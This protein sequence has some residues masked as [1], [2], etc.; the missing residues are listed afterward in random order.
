MHENTKEQKLLDFKKERRSNLLF[1]SMENQ[2]IAFFFR[3]SSLI[4][5]NPSIALHRPVANSEVEKLLRKKPFPNFIEGD[6]N[7]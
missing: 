5:P 6:L 3:T 1:I 2:L 7:A 4:I